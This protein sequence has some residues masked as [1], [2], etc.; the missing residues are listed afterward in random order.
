MSKALTKGENSSGSNPLLI[1]IDSLAID[2]ASLKDSYDTQRQTPTLTPATI[3]NPDAQLYV[4]SGYHRILAAEDTIKS[5]QDKINKANKGKEKMKDSEQ[6]S[7]AE[8]SDDQSIK[9]YFTTA[10]QAAVALEQ[11]IMTWETLQEL[12]GV[13]P[14]WF[15]DFGESQ[16]LCRVGKHC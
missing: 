1:A 9:G 14:A 5:V 15:Y 12:T 13:W 6:Y 10:K 11:E 2:S 4:L 8:S 3:T 16:S 7:P